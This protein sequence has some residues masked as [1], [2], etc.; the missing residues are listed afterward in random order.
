MTLEGCVVRL[1]DT[2]GY[3]GRDIEDAIEL[4][5][6]ERDDI[7]WRCREEL[8][9]TNGT[10]VYTLV[11]D[12]I[13]NSHRIQQA[14]EQKRGSETDRIA[15]SSQCGALLL[16]LKTFNYER[17]YKNP[18]LQPDMSRVA[19]CYEQLFS[20]FLSQLENGADRSSEMIRF[21]GRMD[22]DYRDRERPAA[23][24]RDFIA[25]MTDDYFL[26]RA[27]AIGCTLPERTCLPN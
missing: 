4:G 26:R 18:A 8:G 22:A 24:V 12:L 21:I 14:G 17:I 27:E 16:E 10:I 1:A 20:S 7:P 6:I 2:I 23:M 25:G 13:A 15:F 5:L 19:D 3:I 11:T 9:A